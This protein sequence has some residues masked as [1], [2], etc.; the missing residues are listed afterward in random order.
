MSSLSIVLKQLGY[1]VLGSDVKDDYFTEKELIRN[2]I[3]Y[4]SFDKNNIKDDY[5]YIS[6]SC[7]NEENVEVK[8]VKRRNLPFFYY[9]EFLANFFNGVKIG[10]CGTHGKT[11]TVSLLEKLFD[12]E[13]CVIIRGDGHGKA[14]QEYEYYIFE[15]CEYKDH[16]LYYNYDYLV[17]NNIDLDH[18]DYFKDEDSIISS[19]Q[20]VA[21]KSKCIIVNNDND[22]ICKIKHDNIVTF[23]IEKNSDFMA[24]IK[25]ENQKGFLLEINIKNSN[26]KILIQLPVT[27]RHMIYN[28]LA[29]FCIYY[30]NKLDI[31]KIQ[32]KLDNY[33]LPNRRLE[34]IKLK[35][36][37][38]IVVVDYAHHPTEI[39]ACLEALKQKYEKEIIVIFQP[40]TYSRTLKLKKEF[41]EVFSKLESFYLCNTFTSKREQYD[42]NIEKEVR[43][44]FKNSLE[45]ND[46]VL[47]DISKLSN[48][49]ILFLGAG[50]L[51]KYI[52]TL[53]SL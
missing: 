16:F 20:K 4:T 29:S 31:K 5:I 44:I 32:E 25:E 50:A 41:I 28:F 48:K 1:D 19:F 35:N 23:G 33:H 9:H 52:K 7:Y 47:I 3:F 18:L 38:N 11:T 45:F 26:E 22:L 39:K 27:G 17:I 37:D 15:A 12:D 13:K 24:V 40:H 51:D 42:E 14:D 10:V 53:S 30:L 34:E 6:S 8:E 2:G 43:S 49:V 21:N 46:E 36:S